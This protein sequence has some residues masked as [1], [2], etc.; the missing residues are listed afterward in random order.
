[1]DQKND[2]P[3]E[4][5]GTILVASGDRLFAELVGAM[6]ARCGFTPRTLNN[7]RRRGSRYSEH[8]RTSSSVIAPPRR[9]AFDG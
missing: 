6:V 4:H 2:A 8:G 9:T 1:M 5:Q 7:R 3:V